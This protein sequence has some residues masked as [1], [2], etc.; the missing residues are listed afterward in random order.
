MLS[1]K[2]TTC[3]KILDRNFSNI[4]SGVYKKQKIIDRKINAINKLKY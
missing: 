2:I 3:I 1:T 4:D